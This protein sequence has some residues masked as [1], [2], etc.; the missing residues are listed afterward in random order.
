M[1]KQITLRISDDLLLPLDAA[2]QTFAFYSFR[3]R[4][5][6]TYTNTYAA[7]VQAH[8]QI[9]NTKATAV[10]GADIASVCNV[11]KVLET[12]HVRLS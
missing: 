11:C 12:A 1:N 2:T 3:L 10:N 8:R 7:R 6:W 4:L 9:T 5:A